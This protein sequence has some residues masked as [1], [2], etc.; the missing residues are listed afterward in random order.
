MQSR[1]SPALLKLTRSLVILAVVGQCRSVAVETP[2]PASLLRPRDVNPHPYRNP[3]EGIAIFDRNL[4]TNSEKFS[5]NLLNQG[6]VQFPRVRDGSAVN[7]LPYPYE[8]LALKERQQKMGRFAGADSPIV[9]PAY[10][11]LAKHAARLLGKGYN[12]VDNIDLLNEAATDVKKNYVFSYAVKDSASGDDFSH[13]QQQQMDGAVK[14]SYKVQLPDGRMQIVKYIADNNGYRADVTYE[15]EPVATRQSAPVVNPS[16]PVAYGYYQ[17][18][19][20]VEQQQHFQQQHLQQ[21]QQQQQEQ[22][23]QQQYIINQQQR[24][25]Y[26][27]AT[28]SQIPAPFYP[29]QLRPGDVKIHSYNTAPHAGSVIASTTT[30]AT[31]V[32]G[33]TYLATFPAPANLA[34]IAT[35]SSPSP[36]TGTVAMLTTGAPLPAYRDIHVPPPAP[37]QPIGVAFASAGRRTTVYTGAGTRNALPAGPVRLQQTVYHQVQPTFIADGGQGGV[38]GNLNYVQGYVQIPAT[39]NRVYRRNTDR[40][41]EVLPKGHD[42]RSLDHDLSKKSQTKRHEQH[43]KGSASA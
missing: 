43:Q 4:A 42:Q 30:Q 36:I 34:Y 12:H 7:G 14:G 22:Q 27:P 28:Q 18:P 8:A 9:K 38:A 37:V 24:Q 23:Q 5:Q 11:A 25:L 26:Y 6:P 17:M 13:T 1:R 21:Q 33:G 35:P 16:T 2:E 41:T 3:Y 10:Q 39:E 20:G 32:V 40:S 29:A 31:P 15:N 19:A